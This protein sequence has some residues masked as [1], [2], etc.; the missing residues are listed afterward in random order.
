[1]E[2][3]LE[4]EVVAIQKLLNHI[5]N[6]PK[7]RPYL[8]EHPFKNDRVSVAISFTDENNQRYTDGSIVYIYIRLEIKF[9]TKKQKNTLIRDIKLNIH[10]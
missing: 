2:E 9:F 5:N 1:L 3:T 10:K 6:H 8:R 7:I 4:L